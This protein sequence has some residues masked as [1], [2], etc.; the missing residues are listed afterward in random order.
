MGL[1]LDHSLN[2]TRL[3]ICG[4]SWI[5]ISQVCKQQST[6]NEGSSSIQRRILNL[7]EQFEEVD[8]FHVLKSYNSKVDAQANSGV[9][10]HIGQVE[11]DGQA[12]EIVF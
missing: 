5:V 11:L 10:L 9:L 1:H 8:M 3:T 6:P 7:L 2:Y 12:H 4:D